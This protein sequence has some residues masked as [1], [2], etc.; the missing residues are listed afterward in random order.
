MEPQSDL[1]NESETDVTNNDTPSL[2]TDGDTK[3][4]NINSLKKNIWLL[5]FLGVGSFLIFVSF[6]YTLYQV[7]S[8]IF[9]WGCAY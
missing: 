6:I 1:K 8:W 9:C 2:T 5:T 4:K 7:T 3:T